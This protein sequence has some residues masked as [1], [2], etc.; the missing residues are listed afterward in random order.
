MKR[1]I[2]IALVVIAAAFIISY[3]FAM[4]KKA[5]VKTE[6]VSDPY[7]DFLKSELKYGD[8][9]LSRFSAADRKTLYTLITEYS[10]KGRK[11]MKSDPIYKDVMRIKQYAPELYIQNIEA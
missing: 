11:V 10:R 9:F 3:Y 4:N 8:D 6:N 7:T 2:L 1:N 5:K